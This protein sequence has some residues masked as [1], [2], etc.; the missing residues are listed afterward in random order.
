MKEFDTTDHQNHAL[1][2]GK[3]ACTCRVG[4]GSSSSKICAFAV[5]ICE[6]VYACVC[7]RACVCACA[8]TV[9]TV[10]RCWP[11]ISTHCSLVVLAMKRARWGKV[12]ENGKIS[13]FA[14]SDSCSQRSRQCICSSRPSTPTSTRAAVRFSTAWA[15]TKVPQEWYLTEQTNRARE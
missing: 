2:V 10:T 13:S 1:C 3:C 8:C 15:P 6:C 9:S 14:S 11:T 4:Q 12:L 5:Y 7:M